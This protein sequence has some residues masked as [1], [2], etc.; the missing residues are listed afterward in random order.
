MRP[1]T[2]DRGAGTGPVTDPFL[3]WLLPAILPALLALLLAFGF[4]PAL[5]RYW[6]ALADGLADW[7]GRLACWLLPV[8][9]LACLAGLAARH[10]L[11]L[12][13]PWLPVLTLWL[14]AAMLVLGAGY[15]FMAGAHVRIDPIYARLSKRGRA[16]VDLAGSILLLA[17]YLVVVLATG[18]PAAIASWTPLA[19]GL[20]AAELAAWPVLEAL[21]V[22]FA[23]L[24]AI[25]GC[26]LM[27]R[28]VLVLRGQYQFA[29]SATS[30]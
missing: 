15:A 13:P 23:L 26:A 25:Q 12:S 27:A 2:C 14:Q 22:A 5:A 4:L 30:H 6:V 8:I 29:P 16:G 9:G 7:T 28:S 10:W 11:A 24:L 18:L 17:P 21:V 3:P 19:Q 20:P 1:R